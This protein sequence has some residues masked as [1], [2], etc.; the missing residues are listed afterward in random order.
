MSC[1]GSVGGAKTNADDEDEACVRCSK[2]RIV[3]Q[4][5]KY[6]GILPIGSIIYIYNIFRYKYYSYRYSEYHSYS[7]YVHSWRK[8]RYCISL[9]TTRIYFEV[10][11]KCI[12][13]TE[14]YSLAHV[15]INNPLLYVTF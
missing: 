11:Y 14:T 4:F 6:Q 5:E 3:M 12:Q 2:V 8:Y 10:I 7:D 15:S 13:S 9:H 1:Q